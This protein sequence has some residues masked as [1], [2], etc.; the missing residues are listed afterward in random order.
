[1][2]LSYK[3]VLGVVALGA[4]S[5]C[6]TTVSESE[7]R[8]ARAALNESPSVRRELI[9]DCIADRR[10]DTALEKREIAG[11]MRVS[12][13]NYERTFCNRVINAVAR[14]QL[15]RNEINNSGNISDEKF[16]RI[17]RGR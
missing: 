2:R 8:V 14:G 4:L 5:G 16:L 13:A 3:L 15:T 17:L 12:V 11:L 7:Y 6:T 10:R 1:M 9:A